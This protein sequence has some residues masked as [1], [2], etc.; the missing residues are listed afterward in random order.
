MAYESGRDGLTKER[1]PKRLQA[2]SGQVPLNAKVWTVKFERSKRS[3]QTTP[4]GEDFIR[5]PELALQTYYPSFRFE[6]LDSEQERY[7]RLESETKSKTNTQ[8][9]SKNKAKVWKIK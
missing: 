8:R 4:Q 1:L 5:S 9:T 6:S 7:P 3:F 2:T